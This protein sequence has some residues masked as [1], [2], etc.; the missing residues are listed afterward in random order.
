MATPL[1]KSPPALGHQAMQEAFLMR[2]LSSP[3]L[4]EISPNLSDEVNRQIVRSEIEGG[5][6]LRDLHC[7]DALQIEI[8]DWVCTFQ[9]C[10]ENEALVGG[11][12][13]ICPQPVRVQVAGSTWG[14]SMLKQHFIGRG[15]HLEFIHPTLGR[16]VT[17]AIREIR[18]LPQPAQPTGDAPQSRQIL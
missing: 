13:R 8:Q 9:Y 14:G 5:V 16:V 7:G 10:G 4:F 17:A 6:Y 3:S 12:G 15:M 11:H 18:E 2:D 1:A